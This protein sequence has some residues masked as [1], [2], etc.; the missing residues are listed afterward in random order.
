MIVGRDKE[1]IVRR[2]HRPPERSCSHYWPAS[3]ILLCWVQTLAILQRQPIVSTK[4]SIA[5]RGQTVSLMMLVG[6]STVHQVLCTVQREDSDRRERI[7]SGL[8]LLWKKKRVAASHRGA[9]LS[10]RD[11]GLVPQCMEGRR[12]IEKR[13][14]CEWSH[15]RKRQMVGAHQMSVQTIK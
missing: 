8:S 4:P 7:A 11:T 1:I 6:K 12:K 9:P 10:T 13:M 14:Q 3:W 2:L 5:L 15:R